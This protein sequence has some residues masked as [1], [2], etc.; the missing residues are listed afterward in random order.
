MSSDKRTVVVPLLIIAVGVGWL[1]TSLAV[2]PQIDWIWTIGLA[3]VGIVTF[4]VGGWNKLTFVVGAFFL[5][6][7]GCSVLR[8]LGRLPLDVE[9]PILFITLGLLLLAARHPAI[10]SP[11][12]LEHPTKGGI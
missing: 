6:A 4:V 3:V 5:F 2:T 10:P 7:S 9:L 12:W 8:Q 11:N 1:L